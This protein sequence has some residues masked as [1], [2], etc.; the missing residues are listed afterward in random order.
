MIGTVIEDIVAIIEDVNKR[1]SEIAP[2]RE[3]WGAGV[4]LFVRIVRRLV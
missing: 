4:S 3:V 2:W 1:T